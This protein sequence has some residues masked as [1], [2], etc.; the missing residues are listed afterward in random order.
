VIEEILEGWAK[1]IDHEDIVQAFLA[2]VVDI[3]DASCALSVMCRAE[4]QQ[5]WNTHGIR[6]RSCMFYTHH[7]VEEHHSSAVPTPTPVSNSVN[8]QDARCS[9]TEDD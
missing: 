2:K 1:E 6:P 9:S 4:L 3:R 8:S 7:A 5:A